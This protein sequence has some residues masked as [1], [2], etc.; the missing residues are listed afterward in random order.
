M[1]GKK[2]LLGITGSI[3]AYRAL[4]VARLLVQDGHD[5]QIVAT[6]RALKFFPR[7]N[8]EV[9]TGHMVLSD[10]FESP[11]GVRHIRLAQESDLLLVAPASADFIGRMALGLADDLLTTLCLAIRAPIIIAPAMEEMMYLHPAVQGHL[12][13][14]AGRGVRE[15]PPDRGALASGKE[16]LGRL[17]SPERIRDE[18]R[19]HLKASREWAGVR[20]LISA[21]PTRERLDPVRYIGNRSS[22]RMGYA[23]A[24]A[25]LDLGAY[26]TLVSGPVEIPPPPGAAVFRV[27][28]AGEM[29][30]AMEE[31]FP[32]HD[33]CIM[34]A[35]VADYRMEKP[36]GRKRKK[37]G[38]SWTL[39]L[40]ENPDI[41]AGLS[42]RKKEGQFL[43]GFAAET[44]SLDPDDLARKARRK[45]VDLL[46][47]NDVSEP[48]I[49]FGS[50]SNDLTLV[51]PDGQI[52]QL[53]RDS[54][55]HLADRIFA[56]IRKRWRASP[57]SRAQTED[58][59][60]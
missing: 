7:I 53:G 40:S 28:T 31:Q 13:T 42:R 32:G 22:G 57:P 51:L 19:D 17:A 1:S 35:A 12:K 23:L 43:V 5:V 29:E 36:L 52:V 33:L 47:A 15:I 27:E 25:A 24:E 59:G 48:G 60:S 10:L 3:A 41:L 39:T 46:L 44:R 37:D 38:K 54:K 34:A 20:V 26:V 30:S 14:L 9:F 56:E 55:R 58:G 6:S 21:G 16:G 2:V 50:E 11:G 18:V 45:G 4:D 8:G 49:G